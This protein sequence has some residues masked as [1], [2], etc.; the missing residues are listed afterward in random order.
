MPGLDWFGG[1]Y[2]L[3]ELSGRFFLAMPNDNYTNTS[4]HELT[5]DPATGGFTA[6]PRFSTTGWVYQMLDVR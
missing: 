2:Y 6:I 4:V 1:G 5:D 3:F